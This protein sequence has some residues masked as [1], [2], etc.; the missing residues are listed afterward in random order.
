MSTASMAK[1]SANR[2]AAVD[3][4]LRMVARGQDLRNEWHA[5]QQR[6]IDRDRDTT[7]RLQAALG[8]A[9]DWHAFGDAWQQSLS[10]YAQASSIIW[11]DTA[12]WAVR[13]QREC[14]NAA[15]DWLR[16]CQTAGLQDWGRMAGTP[17]DGRST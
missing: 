5:L 11:L 3:A 2:W 10:A 4:T 17:P 8:D 1:P 15:I 6:R 14:M 16:D 13:A 7:R 9:H 12:A